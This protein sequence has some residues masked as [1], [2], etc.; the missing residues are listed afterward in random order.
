MVNVVKKVLNFPTRV[1][2]DFT[3][4][5]KG[6]GQEGRDVTLAH[7]AWFEQPLDPGEL[8]AMYRDNWLA[9]KICDLPAFD[10]TRAWRHWHAEDDRIEKLEK[11]E[12]DLNL[13]RHMFDAMRKAR[14]YGGAALVMGIEGQKFQDELD[15][16]AVG[17]GDLKFVHVV[18]R[19]MIAAGPRIRDVTSPWFLE[20]NYYMRPNVAVA[21]PIGE[22]EPVPTSSLGQKEGQPLYIP[23]PRGSCG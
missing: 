2:D 6:F 1:A 7:R 16:E 10:S 20:P 23:T 15:V 3:N 12:R 13:Q 4:F 17:E 22:V 18:A 19:W 5:L 8:H 21:P 14:L 11:C 9:R